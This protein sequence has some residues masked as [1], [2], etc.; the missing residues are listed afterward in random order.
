MVI[1]QATQA[2]IN[3]IT[4][5]LFSLGSCI[6]PTGYTLMR[7]IEN[8]QQFNVTCTARSTLLPNAHVCT[9]LAGSTAYQA[10]LNFPVSSDYSIMA[11]TAKTNLNQH[12]AACD[13]NTA[14]STSVV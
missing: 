10:S 3:K 13:V 2:R 5:Q 14:A 7:L 4:R 1:N 12:P 6:L 11:I 9:L 8:D